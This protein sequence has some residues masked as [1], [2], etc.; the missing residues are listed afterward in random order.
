[1]VFL[2]PK[3]AALLSIDWTVRENIRANQRVLVKRILRRYGYPP[4]KQ[5][6]GDADA[7]G[8]FVSV[9]STASKKGGRYLLRLGLCPQSRNANRYCHETPN[10]RSDQRE[11]RECASMG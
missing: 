8:F 2:Q 7:T 1:M 6:K 9:P 10:D 5:G 11:G 3:L 4:D